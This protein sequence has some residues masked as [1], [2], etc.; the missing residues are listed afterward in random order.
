MDRIWLMMRVDKMHM[1]Q[2][3]IG[4]LYGRSTCLSYSIKQPFHVLL[5]HAKKSTQYMQCFDTN[6]TLERGHPPHNLSLIYKLYN[7]LKPLNFTTHNPTMT[8]A[9]FFLFVEKHMMQLH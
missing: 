5:A 4:H 3:T 8:R 7:Q 6:P 9:V 2:P 1:H